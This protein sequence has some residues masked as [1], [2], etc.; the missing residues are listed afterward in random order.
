[1]TTIGPP[2]CYALIP[3][4]CNAASASRHSLQFLNLRKPEA[5]SRRQKISDLNFPLGVN[6]EA[7]GPARGGLHSYGLSTKVICNGSSRLTAAAW[8]GVS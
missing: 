1:M 6:V 3:A 4:T 2:I 5:I 7:R 8:F